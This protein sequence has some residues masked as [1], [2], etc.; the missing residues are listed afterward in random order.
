MWQAI[1]KD[2]ESKMQKTVD[3]TQ[4]EFAAVRTGRA[5]NALVENIKILYYGAPTPLKQIANISV[6]EPRL[7]VIQ[8]W[9]AN[10][11]KDVEKGI[12]AA[13]D[14]GLQPLVEGKIIRITIPPLTKERREELVKVVKKMS[15]DGKVHLRTIRRDGNEAIKKAEKD[16]KVTEDESTKAQEEIQKL[17]DRYTKRLDELSATKEKEL[18]TV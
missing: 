9:D 3:A 17:T 2:I 4:H 11:L 16:K 5:S 13:S 7:I 8:P 15:E 12:L 18:V 14:L 10:A 6:P 1:L